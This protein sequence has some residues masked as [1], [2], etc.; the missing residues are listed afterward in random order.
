MM[1]LGNKNQQ[2]AQVCSQFISIFNLYMFRA[3][4]LLIIRRYYSEHAAISICHAHNNFC[5][6]RKVPPDVEQKVCSKHA[7]VKYRNT[8]RVKECLLLVLTAQIGQDLFGR[9]VRS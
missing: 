9:T 4:L 1:Y 7:E 2:G 6:Y 3:G 8:L 5:T